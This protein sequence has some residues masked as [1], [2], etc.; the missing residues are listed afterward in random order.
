MQKYSAICE[1][2][3]E[4]LSRAWTMTLNGMGMQFSP[5]LASI[6]S[7]TINFL[8]MALKYAFS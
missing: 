7:T 3:K 5:L 1:S 4:R 6:A 2:V 8:P